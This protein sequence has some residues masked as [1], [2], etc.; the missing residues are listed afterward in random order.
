MPTQNRSRR[1]V[2]RWLIASLVELFQ[3]CQEP[4]VIGIAPDVIFPEV[5]VASPASPATRTVESSVSLGL[6][7]VVVIKSLLQRLSFLFAKI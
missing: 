6:E 5:H 2:G 4:V 1:N 7:A 3:F